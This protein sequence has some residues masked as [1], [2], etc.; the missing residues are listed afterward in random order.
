MSAT[1]VKLHCF[2]CRLTCLLDVTNGEAVCPLGETR[3]T[4][5]GKQPAESLADQA[6]DPGKTIFEH[7]LSLFRRGHGN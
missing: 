6:G 3:W 1:G 7:A 2:R 4:D 5:V